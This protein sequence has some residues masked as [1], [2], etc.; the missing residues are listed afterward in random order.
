MQTLATR[1][2]DPNWATASASASTGVRPSA[3]RSLDG[4]Q[5]VVL[6][7]VDD[8]VAVGQLRHREPQLPEVGG[9]QAVVGHGG[10]PTIRWTVSAKAFHSRRF[11]LAAVVPCGVSE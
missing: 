9:D 4:L 5:Q 7:L 6:G 10:A 2:A 11:S 3:T 8:L 1:E